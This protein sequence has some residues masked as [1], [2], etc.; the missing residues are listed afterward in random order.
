MV[1]AETIKNLRSRNISID[2]LPVVGRGDA[3]EK[4]KVKIIGPRKA[5]PGGGFGLR[6]F[7]Y[8]IK[9]VLSG[10]I[11]KAA[12]QIQLLRRSR[13]K[14]SLVVGIGDIVPIFYS[15]LTGSRFVFIGVNK[16]SYYK[17]LAFNYIALEKRLLNKYCRLTFARDQRTAEDLKEH[18]IKVKYVGNPMMD[19]VRNIGRS[20]Y[21]RIRGKKTIGFLPGTRDDAYKNIE[22]FNKIAWQINEMDSK[23]GFIMSLPEN[24]DTKK[25]AGIKLL[26]KIAVT[27][28]FNTVLSSSDV[29]IGLSGTGNEQAAGLGIPI[30][31]FPGRGA[32][33]NFKF[34]KGQKELL[35][36]ALHILNR[37]SKE[38]ASAAIS[39][40]NDPRA[41]RNMGRTGMQ[42]MGKPGASKKIAGIIRSMI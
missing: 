42:R 40:L 27:R 22:D 38:I 13:G 39:L 3:F 16:S 30:L 31:S 1:A 2:V 33:Y 36:D 9:D 11:W 25:I 26:K 23:I 34:A 6:N 10:L 17:K 21:R 41:M 35:G 12:S 4:L 15:M 8:F 32:Q 14:Y 5:L 29:I 19:M 37:N 24:L 20:G 18:G 28:D 7:S